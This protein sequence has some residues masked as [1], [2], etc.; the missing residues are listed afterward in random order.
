MHRYVAKSPNTLPKISNVTSDEIEIR[1]AEDKDRPAITSVAQE[2]V[3]SG[4]VF[5]FEDAADVVDY[6]YQPDAHIYVSVRGD[7]ILGT[8]VVKPNQKGRGAHIAN[9]GYMVRDAAMGLGIGTAMGKHSIEL[10][11]SLGF[12]AM[13]FNMVVATNAGAVHL[14]KKLGFRIVGDLPRVFRHPEHGYV[15]AFV[16]YRTL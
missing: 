14:W 10:A 16:M 11:K 12:E 3:E 7:E 2:V 8:Y 15:D 6:W 4:T 13:Q 9:A 1:A 5:V